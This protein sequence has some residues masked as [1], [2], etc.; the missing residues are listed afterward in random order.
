[1]DLRQLRYFVAVAE[2]L[3]FSRAAE[4]LYISQSSLSYHIAELEKEIGVSLFLRDRRHVFLTPAGAAILPAAKRMLEEERKLLELVRGNQ[5]PSAAHVL[6]IC[7]DGANERFGIVGITNAIARLKR[8]LP[9]A[10]LQFTYRDFDQMMQEILACQTDL[11]FCILQH[12]EALNAS[13]NRYLI[14]ED[15]L[16]LVSTQAGNMEDIAGILERLELYLGD[17]EERWNSRILKLLATV[18]A[19]PRTRHIDSINTAMSMV[20]LGRAAMIL[21][22]RHYEIEA[23]G[24]P[25]LQAIDFTMPAAKA[26]LY[27]IWAKENYN[28]LIQ[29]LLNYFN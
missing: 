10:E 3:H 12:D 18:G 28:P 26:D 4:S 29:K 13:L 1:M 24:K 14:Y 9:G 17:P 23:F 19:A 2:Q 11:C 16:A 21:P 22:R 7:L 6:S 5:E 15:R 20:E 25:A 27:A 8:D